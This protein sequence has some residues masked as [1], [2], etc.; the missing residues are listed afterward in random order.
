MNPCPWGEGCELYRE[1]HGAEWVVPLNDDSA[2]FEWLILDGVQAGLSY[3]TIL[4]KGED[5]RRDELVIRNTSAGKHHFDDV[6]LDETLII[7]TADLGIIDSSVSP[8]NKTY[9]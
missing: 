3:A 6:V 4:K 7:S 9:A 8:F 1:Q 5:Y 2:L